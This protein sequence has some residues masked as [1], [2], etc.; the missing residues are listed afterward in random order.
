MSDIKDKRK[1]LDDFWELSALVPPRSYK[2]P[3]PRSTDTVEIIDGTE[4]T[5][6]TKDNGVI[7]RFIPPHSELE[8]SQAEEPVLVYTPKNSL[9]HRVSLYKKSSQY[10]FYADFCN[11]ARELWSR[12]G[13]RCEYVELFSYMP[14]YDLLSEEQLS[15]YLWW[16]SNVRRGEYIRTDIAYIRLYMNEL[17]NAWDMTSPSE[18]RELMI[19]VLQNYT[20]LLRGF[21]PTYIKWVSDFSLVHR[22]EP[23][24]S[25]SEELL[26]NASSLKE[27]FAVVSGTGS[28]ALAETLL[29]YCCSYDYRTSRFATGDALALYDVHVPAALAKAVNYLSSD[30]GALSSL[31]FDDCKVVINAFEGALRSSDNRY[32]IEV[33]YCSFS[34]SHELRFLVG[35]IVKYCENKLRAYIGVKSRLTVYSL[36]NDVRDVLDGYFAEKLPTRRRSISQKP[37]THEYDA[38]YELPKRKLDLSNAAQIELASWQTTRALVEAFGDT[39]EA[40]NAES[41]PEKATAAD[42]GRSSGSLE[43][44]AISEPVTEC[45]ETPSLRTALGKYYCAVAELR[46]GSTETLYS[47]SREL[48]R[49]VESLADEI[50]EIAV[51][52]IGDVLLEECE[53]GYGVVSEYADML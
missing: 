26:K 41:E 48:S 16:R 11:T 42:G 52:L 12:E 19:C 7:K 53:N 30:G 1:E 47:L 40:E 3:V 27:Y 10:A 36:P 33:E 28:D 9:I 43:A 31:T 32:R 24:Q 23:P 38:L 18:A 34:R 44:T 4:Q 29:G 25:F 15:Y 8:T 2:R 39:E 22:L 49:P 6:G 5:A 51:E 50:N 46:D 21:L 37:E 20:G 45:G 17:I 13:T 35:D 14:Q